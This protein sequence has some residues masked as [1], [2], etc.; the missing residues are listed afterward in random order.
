M[1]LLVFLYV[2]FSRIDKSGPEGI[3]RCL[4]DGVQSQ[5]PEDILP[6]RIDSMKA[7]EA[8]LS[9]FPGGHTQGDILQNLHLRTGKTS[10]LSHMVLSR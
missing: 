6:M 7:G 4:V 8:F 9:D 3:L 5:L 1:T 10:V 2:I